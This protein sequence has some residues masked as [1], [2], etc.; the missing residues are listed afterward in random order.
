MRLMMVWAHDWRCIPT[1][2]ANKIPVA[3]NS[4]GGYCRAKTCA[5][6]VTTSPIDRPFDRLAS[7]DEFQRHRPRSS[8]GRDRLY[9][10]DNVP[11]A[12]R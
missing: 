5:T 9:V 11:G 4:R 12:D 10:A 1:S 2:L 8:T 6:A 7:A 3:S